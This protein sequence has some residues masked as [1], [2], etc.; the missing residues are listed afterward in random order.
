MSAAC[1]SEFAAIC[2]SVT[3]SADFFALDL[4]SPVTKTPSP[5]NS[6]MRASVLQSE[7]QLREL[8][9]RGLAGDAAAQRRLL[10]ELAQLLRMFHRR[11]LGN[12]VAEVED[13]VQETLIA[14][15]TR[16]ATYDP[17]QPFTA[18][19]YALARYKLI[20]HLRRRRI[21]ATVS[22]DDSAEL[23]GSDASDAQAAA[24]DVEN[25]LAELPG[26]QREAIRLTRIEGLSVEEAA[27]RTGQSISSIKVG[28]HRGLKKLSAL[29]GGN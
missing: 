26:A 12:D 27:L 10:T 5:A 20:D 1:Q 15:H 18:W 3:V 25:L 9:L 21:R 19:A 6:Y 14:I 29:F 22:L 17:A 8:M 13:L 28:V 23:F 11:R 2:N 24:Q 4:A 7:T 16:R